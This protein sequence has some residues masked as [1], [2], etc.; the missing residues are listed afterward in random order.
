M[1]SPEDDLI[2]KLSVILTIAAHSA[3]K[4][5]NPFIR[6]EIIKWSFEKALKVNNLRQ[7]I[8]EIMMHLSTLIYGSELFG[9]D[10]N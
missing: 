7:W 3:L 9:N 6:D 4:D 5:K 1:P 8:I 10:E 2:G